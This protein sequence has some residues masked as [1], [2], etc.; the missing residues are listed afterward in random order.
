MTITGNS[1]LLRYRA[2]AYFKSPSEMQFRPEN[3]ALCQRPVQLMQQEDAKPGG[4]VL[5]YYARHG[6]SSTSVVRPV[7]AR[8]C[9]KTTRLDSLASPARRPAQRTAH[10]EPR[11]TSVSPRWTAGRQA[12]AAV[13]AVGGPPGR[14]P[15]VAPYLQTLR[16]AATALHRT[17]AYATRPL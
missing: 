16:W 12:A 11:P 5:E 8:G 4:A 3:N 17:S 10:L 1:V 9:K 13:A 6:R 14:G 15:A 7:A 2:L